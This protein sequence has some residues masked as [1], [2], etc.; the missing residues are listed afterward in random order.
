[1]PGVATPAGCNISQHTSLMKP[2]T[3]YEKEVWALYNRPGYLRNNRM[4]PAFMAWVKAQYKYS[5]ASLVSKTAW[6]SECGQS[7]EVAKGATEVV[8]PHCGETLKVVKSRRQK[9]TDDA[10]YIQELT[11]CGRWQVI[12]TYH[13]EFDGHKGFK[14]GIYVHRCYEKWID[15]EGHVVVIARK[16]KTFP[17]YQRIP[18]SFRYKFGKNNKETEYW[19]EEIK[20]SIKRPEGTCYE[21]WNIQHVYPVARIQPWLK[22]YGLTKETHGIDF[23]DLVLNLPNTEAE[24]YWKAGEYMLASFFMFASWHTKD[25]YGPSIKV[26]RR[27]GFNFE[28]LEKMNDYTDY[29]RL[30]KQLGRDIHNPSVVAPADFN[31]AHQEVIDETARRREREE[32]RRNEEERRRRAE[33]DKKAQAAYEKD[34]AKFLDLTFQANGLSFHVLQ[35]VSE[36]YDVG[37]KMHICVY[38]LKYY[39]KKSSLILCATDKDGKRVE[40]I[41]VDLKGWKIIQSRAACNKASTRH[42]DIINIVNN[43]MGL[44][45]RTAR[46]SA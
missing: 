35:N 44:I 1:M 2:R 29:L 45:K 19:G 37:C 3:K 34:K 5:E 16:L 23:G 25:E 39:E 15:E 6:C 10:N 36:F 13:V 41:E 43:N 42:A 21:D 26:A 28:Q 33:S 7:F 22:R 40:I 17:S 4:T 18:W 12:K 38:S 31:A 20:F 32:Q 8:C 27:H 11:T 30:S 24:T 46:A 9:I 14:G